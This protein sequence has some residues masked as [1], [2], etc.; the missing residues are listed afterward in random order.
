M[1]NSNAGRSL[2]LETEK[3]TDAE[4]NTQRKYREKYGN[5]Q[6]TG[7]E[8]HRNKDKREQGK[9]IQHLSLNFRVLNFI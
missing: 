9:N 3:Y 6:Y 7:A 2:N 5:I 1:T 4:E 8:E